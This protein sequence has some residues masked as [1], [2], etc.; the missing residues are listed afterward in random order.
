MKTPLIIVSAPSGAGKSS[1]CDRALKEIPELVDSISFTTRQARAGESQGAPYFFVSS[2]EFKEKRDQGFFIEWAEVHGN[3]YGT[4]RYQLDDA[5]KAKKH[6]I[7]DV[8]VQGAASLKRLYP[9]ATSIFILPPSIESLRHRIITRDQGKTPN[10]ET[11][12]KNAEHE[13]A[14]AHHF[15]FHVVNDDFEVAY[16]Q[17]KKIIEE[18]VRHG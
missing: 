8:D 1:L 10:L 14:Q 18:L 15:D 5:W 7:M 16:T 6:L 2:T 4:P 12:L 11:R 17:F 13:I 9:T 3:L